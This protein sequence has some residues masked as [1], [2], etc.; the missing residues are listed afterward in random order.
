[1]LPVVDKARLAGTYTGT[2]ER[3]HHHHQ[4]LLD[5]WLNFKM[6]SMSTRDRDSV[7]EVRL[8]VSAR[9]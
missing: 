3:H 2:F 7:R 5:L 9:R 6:P 1:M 8:I 4:H